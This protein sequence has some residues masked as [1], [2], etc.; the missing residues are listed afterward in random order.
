MSKYNGDG[1]F[2]VFVIKIFIVLVFNYG[3]GMWGLC[4]NYIGFVWLVRW[5]LENLFSKF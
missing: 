1:W 2:D 3:D 4:L 5:E